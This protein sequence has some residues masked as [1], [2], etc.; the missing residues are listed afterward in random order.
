MLDVEKDIVFFDSNSAFQYMTYD[1]KFLK[2]L[3]PLEYRFVLSYDETF[4][5][6]SGLDL[7]NL[8]IICSPK[9]QSLDLNYICDKFAINFDQPKL[10][11]LVEL[12]DWCISKLRDIPWP[13]QE[14]CFSVHLKS[15][16]LQLLTTNYSQ[17]LLTPLQAYK[18]YIDETLFNDFDSNNQKGILN[19]PLDLFEEGGLMSKKLDDFE[20]RLSQQKMTGIVSDT[21]Q[22]SKFSMVEAATGTGKTFAYLIAALRQSI[23]EKTCVI[24]TTKTKQL[25][26][27]IL[28]KDIPFLKE[29]LGE[30]SVEVVKGRSNYID[31]GR[32]VDF[33]QN[34]KTFK[35]NDD[36]ARLL[37]FYKFVLETPDGDLTVLNDDFFYDEI[38][39]TRFSQEIS[40]FNLKFKK[41]CFLQRIRDRS[42]RAQLIITNHH[43]YLTNV[44]HNQSVFPKSKY[45]VIDEAH[46]FE[47]IAI[48]C[49]QQVL[50]RDRLNPLMMYFDRSSN[51]FKET[52]TPFLNQLDINQQNMLNQF[53]EELIL[54]F[55]KLNDDFLNIFDSINPSHFKYQQSTFPINFKSLDSKFGDDLMLNI[56]SIH[57]Q[58][59]VFYRM[60]NKLYSVINEIDGS[61]VKDALEF[62]DYIMEF[63]SEF[64]N[65]LKQFV[66]D[67]PN[68]VKWLDKFR[69]ETAIFMSPTNGAE[70]L[71]D[72]VWN[73]LK[74]VI[75]CS[76]TM[77][78]NNKFTYLM[79]RFGWN[80]FNNVDNHIL[81]SEFNLK[82]QVE[83]VKVENLPQYSNDN[84]YQRQIHEII[85]A[86]VRNAD[87]KILILCT[88]IKFMLDC[89]Q[90][91]NSLNL[92]YDIICQQ[93]GGVDVDRF[94]FS[95]K[96]AVLLG[97]DRLWEGVDLKGA[98]LSDVIITKLPFLT[99]SDP[100]YQERA[101]QYESSNKN[102]FYDYMLPLAL[103]KFRQGLGRL[104][105]SSKD[106][107]KIYVL[108]S[109][110]YTKSYGKY[111]DYEL[112]RFSQIREYVNY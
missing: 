9:L 42:K 26:D 12:Y 15:P 28:T 85:G 58:L 94:K 72:H 47:D 20:L 49:Q 48:S 4:S 98:G 44:I 8:I 45:L 96:K 87:S 31:I 71:V 77:T 46:H 104:I 92:N 67:D 112:K 60:L 5:D 52:L 51:I 1:N 86:L 62:I 83:Y 50:H 22:E 106:C 37:A 108:D 43:L 35:S 23:N 41:Y 82:E 13:V 53:F 63:S 19:V 84:H 30:F 107:G 56:V 34:I 88:S 97:C 81:N 100:I 3:N 54:G 65:T 64:I 105:R 69:N 17:K 39:S 93:H 90:Y 111:F 89:F 33:I 61:V 14:L 79:N 109:R 29:I 7:K 80:Q 102:S 59:Q 18:Q 32:F 55:S 99:P 11:I 101:S 24:V 78:V 70:F 38:K 10:Y 103:I 73:D 66:N 68:N 40:K 25:Q 76:A 21:L 6:E 91:L 16:L 27:Q 36:I 57:D 110:V 74:S 2:T 95:T 75:A